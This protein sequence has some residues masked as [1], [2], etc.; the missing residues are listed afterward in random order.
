MLY[1][2]LNALWKIDPMYQYSLKAFIVVFYRAIA[3]VEKVE[4]TV[5]VRVGKL[6]EN[7]TFTVFSTTSR[8]LFERHKVIFAM[9]LC[10][11]IMQAGNEID[12]IEFDYL[13]SGKQ[14]PSERENPFAEFLSTTSWQRINALKEVEA[15]ARLMPDMEAAPKRWKARGQNSCLDRCLMVRGA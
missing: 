14:L 1:F 6:I 2:L 3:R 8:G 5:D 13:V 9:Q 7:I 12:P 10:L 15:F 11:K 4:E